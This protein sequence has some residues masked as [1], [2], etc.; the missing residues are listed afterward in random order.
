MLHTWTLS[1]F[2]FFFFPVEKLNFNCSGS[3][4]KNTGAETGLNAHNVQKTSRK[5]GRDCLSPPLLSPLGPP[6]SPQ[7]RGQ[8]NL[9]KI[10]KSITGRAV[11]KIRKLKFFW[12]TLTFKNVIF[13]PKK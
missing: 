3:L 4:Y 9:R 13:N 5:H 7:P 1:F 10:K 8:W 11:T 12:L 2:S 6:W